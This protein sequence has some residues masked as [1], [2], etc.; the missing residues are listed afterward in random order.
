MKCVDFGEV[1]AV[2]DVSEKEFD[3]EV[4]KSKI[5]VVVDM[6]ASWC[7]APGSIVLKS[8]YSTASAVNINKNGAVLAYDGKRLREARVV[9]SRNSLNSGHCKRI[10]TELNRRIDVTDDHLF[11]TSRGWKGADK[12]EMGDK[13]AVYPL[14]NTIIYTNGAKSKVILNENAFERFADG[15]I[16]LERNLDHLKK[17]GLLP[18]N[19]DNPK[20]GMIARLAGA[21]FSDGSLYRKASN[22]YCCADF[23]LG[24]NGDVDDLLL[25]LKELSFKASVKT[26]TNKFKI[27]GREIKIRSRRV[28]IISTPFWLLMRAMGVPSGRKTDLEYVVPVWLYKVSKA[29][30]REFLSGYLG[31]DGPSL[32]MKVVSRGKRGS[33]NCLGINDIEFYKRSEAIASGLRLGRQLSDLLEEQGVSIKRVFVGER[34]YPRSYGGASRSIHIDLSGSFESG[35]AMASIGYAY[36]SQKQM[37]SGYVMEFLSKKINERKAWR[38]KYQKAV[39][40]FKNGK[41]I[42]EIS[43]S[44]Q[45]RPNTLYGW[46]K[47]GALPTINYSFERYPQWLKSATTGLEAGFVWDS[48]ERVEEIYLPSVQSLTV[49]KYSNFIANGFLVHNCGP[50]RLYSP[51][52]EQVSEEYDKKVKFVKINV[53]DNESLAQRYNVMSIPTT[54]LIEHGEVKTRNVG[55]VSKETLKSWLKKNL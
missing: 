1:M 50:C 2:A 35:R 38:D 24:S 36:C 30:R 45:V 33:Y 55:A 27:G 31:G 25:D 48:V 17:L 11:Y 54:L 10:I 15:K 22:N 8:K 41:G 46:L 9:E 40:M 32:S 37:K 51:V 16:M 49:E 44:L 42:N 12:L 7:V 18:L 52:I 21:L 53:D 29:I 26:R 13:V 6:W 28:R 43:L 19:S 3:S 47:H 5:P 23:I 4:L 39:I 14:A 20:L 34:S